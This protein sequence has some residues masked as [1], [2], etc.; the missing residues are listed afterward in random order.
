M[1]AK[2][3]PFETTFEPESNLSHLYDIYVYSQVSQQYS[4]NYNGAKPQ[5]VQLSVLLN[6]RYR[7]DRWYIQYMVLLQ[8]FLQYIYVYV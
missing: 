4:I 6:Q 7:A 2:K 8:E 5:S 1:F 3:H